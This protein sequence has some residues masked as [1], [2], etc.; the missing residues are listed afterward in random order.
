LTII[1]A[2]RRLFFIQ[3]TNPRVLNFILNIPRHIIDKTLY[4][5]FAFFIKPYPSVDIPIED[6]RQRLDYDPSRDKRNRNRYQSK[7]FRKHRYMKKGFDFNKKQINQH[8]FD[9]SY[10]FKK[11]MCPPVVLKFII[12][13]MF[14]LNLK[15]LGKNLFANQKRNLFFFLFIFAFL[16]KRIRIFMVLVLRNTF[17]IVHLARNYKKQLNILKYLLKFFIIS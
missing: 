3:R 12:K 13:Y 7:F 6:I 2:S 16:L 14:F 10:N 17:S 9:L 1:A 8:K 11:R 4:Y 15:S 5:S